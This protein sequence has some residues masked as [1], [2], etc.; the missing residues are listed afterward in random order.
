MVR[1]LTTSPDAV[2]MVRGHAGTG[3]TS[4]LD[5]CRQIWEGS[6]RTVIGCALSGR[7][8]AELQAGAGIEST[9]ID[10]LLLDLV[11]FREQLLPRGDSILV[12]DEAGMVGTRLLDRVLTAAA[13]SHATVV[14]VGDDCQLPEID[15]GG[16]YRGLCGRLGAVELVE[17]RRQRDEWERQALTL[18]REGRSDEALA[19]YVEHGRVVLGPSADCVRARLVADW[20]AA[21]QLGGGDNIIV[22]L[23]RADV[24]ELNQRARALLVAVGA[25]TGPTLQLPTGEFAVGDRV[26]T[27]RNRR[28][29]GVV[30]GSRGTVAAVDERQRTMRVH[31]DGQRRDEPGRLTVLSTEYLEAGHL[32]HGY[33][34]TGHKAQGMTADRAFVLGDEAIYREWGYVALSRGCAENRLYVVAAELNPT[35][36]AGH[37]RLPA[38]TSERLTLDMVRRALTD[39]HEQRLALKDFEALAGPLRRTEPSPLPSPQP[40][41]LDDAALRAAAAAAKEALVHR[42]PFP[43]LAEPNLAYPGKTVAQ[44]SE[45]HGYLTERRAH[46]HAQMETSR[47]RLEATDGLVAR[48]RHRQ[49]RSWW[50]KDLTVGARDIAEVD[51][52]L[53]QLEARMHSIRGDQVAK[54]AWRQRHADVAQRWCDLHDEAGARIGRRVQ[55]AAAAPSIAGHSEPPRRSVRS[56]SGARRRRRSSVGA[57]GRVRSRPRAKHQR[58]RR[59]TAKLACPW[60]CDRMSPTSSAASTPPKRWLKASA[61]GSLSALATSL[62][63]QRTGS[64]SATL[65]ATNALLRWGRVP[66]LAS[67]RDARCCVY[68]ACSVA[69]DLEGSSVEAS[70]NS[71]EELPTL[72]IA[73]VG[74]AIV[75]GTHRERIRRQPLSARKTPRPP[76]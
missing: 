60:P 31:I 24:Q 30:N 4:A 18:L 71:P 65:M 37:G 8:A 35:D 62:V 23:R 50:Q 69:A 74:C 53:P 15:A 32:H 42:E 3:K 76:R 20:W 40:K 44:L 36:D 16:A 47:V 51:R 21:D 67:P 56:G 28:S 46:V 25:V 43:E 57:S 72:A 11:D 61:S 58:R 63:S 39:S 7:A 54:V 26:V 70:L 17:N 10:R 13:T 19:A 1:H 34:I 22:A 5:A 29:L 68:C 14:L 59:A 41:E 12:V 38:T 73:C 55:A 64:P 75:R 33:A 2:L 27:T 52:Q 6:G 48:R 49:E 45:Q 66:G 9:T